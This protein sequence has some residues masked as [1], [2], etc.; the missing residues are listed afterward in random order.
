MLIRR[1]DEADWIVP[2]TQRHIFRKGHVRVIRRMSRKEWHR[3]II[4]RAQRVI[5]IEEL[6]SVLKEKGQPFAALP[7]VNIGSIMAL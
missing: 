7:S 5:R 1:R 3:I 2:F 4:D 6:L